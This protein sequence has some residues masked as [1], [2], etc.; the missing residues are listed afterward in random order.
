MVT[1]RVDIVIN[2]RGDR[3]VSR[4]LKNV[5]KSAAGA[6]K[7]VFTL[8]R[9][10]GLIGGALIVRQLAQTI[11]AF[12]LLQNRLRVVTNS[13]EELIA[14]QEELFDISQ[15][16]RTALRGNVELFTRLALASRELGKSQAE[17]LQITESLNQAVIISGASA[18]E[19]RNAIIQL[20]QGIASGALRGDELRSVLEQLPV[21]ADVIAKELA[22]TRGELRAFGQTG[23]ITADVIFEAFK[24]SREELE[25]RFL[26]TVP[27]LGQAFTKLSNAV[28]QTTG[29][30]A[31]QTGVAAK[32]AAV[33][34][35]VAENLDIV[36][37]AAVTLGTVILVLLV[38][39]AIPA[40]ILGFK[41]L[42]LVTLANPIAAVAALATGLILFRKELIEAGGIVG[43]FGSALDEAISPQYLKT[44]EDA[45]EDQRILAIAIKG[46]DSQAKTFN[47]TIEVQIK[48]ID[49]GNRKLKERIAVMGGAKATLAAF[50]KSVQNI[51]DAERE[52]VTTSA[53]RL[54]AVQREK[55]VLTA[56]GDILAKFQKQ[57]N[58]VAVTTEAL[59]RLFKDGA[60][61]NEQYNTALSNLEK[62]IDPLEAAINKLNRS[63]KLGVD[64]NKEAAAILLELQ[65]D[66][67]KRGDRL[68]ALTLLLK[69]GLITQKQYNKALKE[70]EETLKSPTF[71]NEIRRLQE[72]NDLILLSATEQQAFNEIKRTELELNRQLT[73]QEKERI[74][75]LIQE[76]ARRQEQVDLAKQIGPLQQFKREFTDLQTLAETTLVNAFQSAEDA[77]VDF[78]TTGKADFKG[79]VDSILRDVARLLVRQGIIALVNA[80]GGAAGGGGGG[81]V[82]A[83]GNLAG[84]ARQAGGSVDPNRSFLVGE[85]GPERFTPDVPGV[86]T[87]TAQAGASIT[88]VNVSD[89]DEVPSALNTPAG[90]QV[91]LN[92]VQR[93]RRNLRRILS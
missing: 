74:R 45:R 29:D 57:Q 15:R 75:L 43:K 89:P 35:F 58:K 78:I 4:N 72:Q 85:R 5:G 47:R 81:I 64:I 87:P 49:E 25:E 24:N 79:L 21:V 50:E 38:R 8:Q 30:F 1:E 71:Q 31:T 82:S 18:T 51:T 63:S 68:S 19:A 59:N 6:G 37:K 16:T 41:K 73:D 23:K 91:V 66:E 86:V 62:N 10:L 3:V 80:L 26:K 76:G 9:A 46:S 65:G 93:N 34:T 27:T 77:L 11:D 92:I 40:L 13:Q 12:T 39:K 69:Q 32:L 7:S 20:S 33:L 22:I 28:T 70:E 36:I 55:E 2:S 53:K 88:V 54:E 60:I 61:T 56:Q 17:V 84:N 42:A 67:Q 14:T 52:L 48:R 90:E 83:L 44:V